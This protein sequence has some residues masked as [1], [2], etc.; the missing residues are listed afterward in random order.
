[1]Q[2]RWGV[3]AVEVDRTAVDLGDRQQLE[4]DR[5]DDAQQTLAA[6]KRPEQVGVLGGGG[7]AQLPVAGDHLEGVH[8]VGGKTRR[9]RASGPMP[10]PVV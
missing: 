10:P 6:P 5:G 4:L 7:P 1:M 8:P 9:S 3:V 2:H